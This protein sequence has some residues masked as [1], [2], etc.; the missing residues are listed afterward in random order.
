MT[1]I[2]NAIAAAGVSGRTV[3]CAQNELSMFQ[4]LGNTTCGQ[5]MERYLEALNA[6]GAAGSLTNPDAT[7][8][9]AYCT[10]KVA[11]QFLVARDV[12]YDQRWRNFG[13]IWVYIVFNVVFAVV[14]YYLLR[15][16]RWRKH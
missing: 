12:E 4:P 3:T 5:Y 16:R 7:D 2:V 10:L 8:N 6:I 15:V 9:C 1:Y 11:D 13:L 14:I